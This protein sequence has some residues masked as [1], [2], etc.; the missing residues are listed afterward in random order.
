MA[1][2]GYS[3]G[4]GLGSGRQRSTMAGKHTANHGVVRMVAL[5]EDHGTKVSVSSN[6]PSRGKLTDIDD[7]AGRVRHSLSEIRRVGG[8][9]P[10]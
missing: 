10:S 8:I 5:L 3:H 9:G 1:E 6:V 7:K 2:L 4:V